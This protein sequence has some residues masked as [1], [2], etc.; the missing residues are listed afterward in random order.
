MIVSLA[1]NDFK[2]VYAGSVLGSVWAVA[3]PLVTLAIYWFVYTVALKG[4]DIDGMPYY[5]WLSVGLA[6]W[7]FVSNGLRM[8]ASAFYDYSYIVKK[9]CFD[10]SILPSVRVVSALLSHALFVGVVIVLCMV[11]GT[12]IN[13]P[14][15]LAA[16]VFAIIFVY[17]LGRILALLCGHFK[18]AQ[19]VT[20]VVL[21]IAFWLT[22]VFWQ[23]EALNE[24]AVRLLYLN[25]VA[26]IVEAYRRAL[27]YGEFT[28]TRAMLYLLAV[29]AVLLGLGSLLEKIIL[30]DIADRL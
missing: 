24:N 11:E 15:L 23:A 26:V 22:P 25:P 8:T 5:I 19:N 6:A 2:A 7:F 1:V 28:E 9:L 20:A 14:A 10:T 21:N 17:A 16:L 30:P 27:L 4:A 18:D 29:C 13:L 12:K 3:E